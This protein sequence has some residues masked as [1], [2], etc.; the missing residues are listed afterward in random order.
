M[1]P[2]NGSSGACGTASAEKLVDA[3]LEIWWV[4]FCNRWFGEEDVVEGEEPFKGGD[5]SWWD[6]C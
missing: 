3:I 1:R 4:M 6:D 2:N 5:E